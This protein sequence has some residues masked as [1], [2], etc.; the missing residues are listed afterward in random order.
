MG[1]MLESTDDDEEEGTMM[2]DSISM[3]AGGWSEGIRVEGCNQI[4]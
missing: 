3:A 1:P 4:A 2:V